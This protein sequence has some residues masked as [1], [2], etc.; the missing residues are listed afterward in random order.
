MRSWFVQKA[1]GQHEHLLVSSIIVVCMFLIIEIAGIFN[2][3]LVSFLWFIRAVPLLQYFSCDTHDAILIVTIPARKRRI[4]GVKT[5][6]EGTVGAHA[7]WK[8]V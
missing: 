2:G 6:I 1:I 4:E 3:D 7:G 5:T 8:K